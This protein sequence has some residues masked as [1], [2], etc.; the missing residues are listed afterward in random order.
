MCVGEGIVYLPK[1]YYISHICYILYLNNLNNF[2]SYFRGAGQLYNKGKCA[3][4]SFLRGYVNS[5]KHEEMG[6][7]RLLAIFLNTLNQVSE[8]KKMVQMVHPMSLN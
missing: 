3:E 5:M 4:Q 2:L 7:G 1:L 6:K 8:D